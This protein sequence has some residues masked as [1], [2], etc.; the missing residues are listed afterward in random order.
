MCV[1]FSVE[2]VLTLPTLGCH[3]FT[4]H[5]LPHPPWI[6]IFTSRTAHQ[7]FPRDCGTVRV[8]LGSPS[9][10]PLEIRAVFRFHYQ[11][12]SARRKKT[13]YGWR[14][15][16]RSRYTGGVVRCVTVCGRCVV[17][18]GASGPCA[19]TKHTQCLRQSSVV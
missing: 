15:S 9:V 4:T 14:V 10:S 13:G 1:C 17:R 3:P 16:F 5:P 11:S 18:R 19:E 2:V 6:H 7:W 8:L 12:G